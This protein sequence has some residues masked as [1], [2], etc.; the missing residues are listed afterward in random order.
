MQAPAQEPSMTHGQVQAQVP[1]GAGRRTTH[2]RPAASDIVSPNAQRQRPEPRAR[3]AFAPLP[4]S[5]PASA[6]YR[7]LPT[8]GSGWHPPR[9]HQ[10]TP[11]SML[12]GIHNLPEGQYSGQGSPFN[13]SMPSEVRAHTA[14]MTQATQHT[15]QAFRLAMLMI[16]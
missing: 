6:Q 11:G 14:H 4:A 13:M 12:H 9:Q 10:A 1:H 15:R 3:G 2:A 8:D 16:A 7:R 5:Q